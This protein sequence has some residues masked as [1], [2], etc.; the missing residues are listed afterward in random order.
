MKYWLMK[1]EPDVFGI[2]HFKARP[3]RTAPWDGVRNYQARN[4]MRAMQR[5]DRVLFYH[6]S[7]PQPGVA[8]IVT[9]VK[10]AY[11][12]HSAW[13]PQSE[14]YDPKSTPQK[15]LWFMV[16][17]KLERELKRL[18]P[19]EAIKAQPALKHMRLVQ[20]GNRLS[21]MPVSAQEWKTILKLEQE[22][23]RK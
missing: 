2:E 21:V 13:D 18:I 8:A 15:P 6:S 4:F 10:E 19:L 5:G 11:P 16:D 20:R 17:V 9:V 12:D 1:S 23:T 3:R 22:Q 7:C 14:Y